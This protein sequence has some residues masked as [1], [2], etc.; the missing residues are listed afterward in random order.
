MTGP[1]D[2]ALSAL[3]DGE[4]DAAQAASLR[5]RMEREPSLA[6]R[7]A[8]L[9]AANRRVRR[10][11]EGVAAEPVPERVRAL[12]V[13]THAARNVAALPERRARL[14]FAPLPTALAA[15]VALAIG[16]A[17]GLL[18]AARAPSSNAGAALAAVGELA[19]ADP[20]FATL[21][22]APS[23]AARD[24]GGGV[25][26]E[27]RLTFRTR[28]GGYCRR[29]DLARDGEAAVVLACRR[30]ER[31]RVEA[32]SFAQVA[33]PAGGEF[34]PATE[35]PSAVEAAIDAAIEGEPLSADAERALLAGGWPG[36]R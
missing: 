7:F 24:L 21:E 11:Y 29:V 8:A 22:T 18:V 12:L 1:D 14:R 35:A 4:L 3:L 5:R 27:P 30:G 19:R 15:S 6:A 2:E 32:A 25:S 16:V 33:A 23:G 9:E 10:A 26:V 20:L 36:A 28:E 31:W 34:R 17:L 13:E